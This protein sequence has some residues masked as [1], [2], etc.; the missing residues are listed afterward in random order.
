MY[1]Y[2]DKE[3]AKKGRVLMYKKS[4]TRIDNIDAMFGK[5]TVV[6][7]IGDS[8]P[9][10]V[11]Y[12]EKSGSIRAATV[13]ERQARALKRL[14]SGV[15]LLGKVWTKDDFDMETF[16][17]RKG[18]TVSG[19]LNITAGVPIII[20]HNSGIKVNLGNGNSG[21]VGK[22][23]GTE[24]I[25]TEGITKSYIKSPLDIS[26]NL[27]VT[28]V[29]NATGDIIGM[30][31]MRIKKDIKPITDYWDLINNMNGYRYTL[32]IDNTKH[33]GLLAQEVERIV[34]EAVYTDADTGYKGIAYGNLVSIC[35]ECIK[36]LNERIKQLENQGVTK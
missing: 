15:E 1:Y 11:V 18:D 14:Y 19:T 26:G 2:I 31:D 22:S 21:L 6:E 8:L 25:I 35:V 16:V 13:E 5:G 17:K 27:N 9:F 33:V 23:S 4:D 12:D 30:S 10:S 3:E 29:V 24:M 7:F 20:P 28:G 36:D 34:P 32:K